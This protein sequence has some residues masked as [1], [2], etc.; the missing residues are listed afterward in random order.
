MEEKIYVG[1]DREKL[2][3]AYFQKTLA[4]II[5]KVTGVE[6]ELIGPLAS[7]LG[8]TFQSQFEELQKNKPTFMRA[9]MESMMETIDFTVEKYMVDHNGMYRISAD[10]AHLANES[11]AEDVFNES[12]GDDMGETLS[13]MVEEMLDKKIND[14]KDI[15]KLVIRMEK[16]KQNSEKEQLLDENDEIEE[17]NQEEGSDGE[18]EDAF[19]GTGDNTEGSDDEGG[20]PFGDDGGSSDNT[21]SGDQDDTAGDNPFGDD[22]SSADGNN[23]DDGGSDNPFEGGSEQQGEAEESGNENPFESGDSGNNTGNGDEGSGNPFESINDISKITI[24]G[25]TPFYSLKNGDLSHF[26][27]S[28]TRQVFEEP[29]RKAFDE[30]GQESVQFKSLTNRLQHTNKIALE[31][32]I[33]IA[34]VAPLLGFKVDLNKIRNWDLY[35]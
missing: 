2:K 6:S 28:Q 4:K 13:D 27:M 34:S 16:D 24:G 31:S 15:A 18:A 30:F 29:M 32:V 35:C 26:V 14:I 19:G 5:S 33:A 17:E 8:I 11:A 9:Y 23:N 7:N 20:N 22:S 25:K 10:K 12:D 3:E 21:E 1:L